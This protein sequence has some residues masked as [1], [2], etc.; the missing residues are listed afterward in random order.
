MIF[1]AQYRSASARLRVEL[2]GVPWAGAAPF[3]ERLTLD[4]IDTEGSLAAHR[5]WF[6]VGED[7]SNAILGR[8]RKAGIKYRSTACGQY[9]V[10]INRQLSGC[11]I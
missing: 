6:Y 3:S 1:P 4:F 10:Q 2:L 8:V 5:Y 9:D 11:N 7:E